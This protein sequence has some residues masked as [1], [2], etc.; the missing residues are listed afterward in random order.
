[1]QP[2]TPR[3]AKLQAFIIKAYKAQTHTQ[4]S[5]LPSRGTLAR[6]RSLR[7]ALAWRFAGCADQYAA[8]QR[9][10]CAP[11]LRQCPQAPIW[12]VIKAWPNC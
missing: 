6:R 1:V 5:T 4:S 3:S 10:F 9:T 8:S 11:F 2:T 12:V 7:H